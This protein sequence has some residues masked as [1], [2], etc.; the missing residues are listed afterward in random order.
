MMARFVSLHKE[1][2]HDINNDHH[3]MKP[4]ETKNKQTN[5]KEQLN[6]EV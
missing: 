6:K 5:E 4:V 3:K 2:D 1:K